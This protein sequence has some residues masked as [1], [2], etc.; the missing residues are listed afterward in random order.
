V[1]YNR[2][3]IA[4]NL[5]P[6]LGHV[7]VKDLRASAVT[8]VFEAL[9]ASD[10]G[11]GTS[12]LARLASILGRVT[13][14]AQYKGIDMPQHALTAAKGAIKPS[15]VKARRVGEALSA[16]E[17][18]AMIAAFKGHRYELPLTVMAY[19]GLR[20]SEVWAL[21]YGAWD[22]HNSTL[23]IDHAVLQRAGKWIPGKVKSP[24]SKREI[25]LVPEATRALKAA[26]DSLGGVPFGLTPIFPGP[27]GWQDVRQFGHDVRVRT[28][29]EPYAL[30]HTVASKLLAAG[31]T[32]P[33]VAKHM[34]HTPEVLIKTYAH[35]MPVTDRAAALDEMAA[36]LA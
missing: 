28:G 31:M 8:E 36:A 20:P 12:T 27:S 14:Y 6:A 5:R 2:R 29:H 35:A 24:A 17:V 3:M 23:K 33:R 21:T 16:A 10:K 19:T 13:W 15:N 26:K 4:V 32:V 34:G 22:E 30:R 25:M 9:A 7:A 1:D 18:A 11:V